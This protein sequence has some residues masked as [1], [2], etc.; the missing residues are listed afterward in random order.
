[1]FAQSCRFVRHQV[2]GLA[3]GQLRVAVVYAS[4]DCSDE[5]ERVDQP[6]EGNEYSVDHE[7]NGLLLDY[8]ELVLEDVV[9]G[10]A[11]NKQSHHC[12]RQEESNCV[13]DREVELLLGVRG[14]A[15]EFGDEVEELR[16][17]EFVEQHHQKY[18]KVDQKYDFGLQT[19]VV[20]CLAVLLLLPQD[21][22]L[23]LHQV[24]FLLDGEVENARD[25]RHEENGEEPA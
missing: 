20:R 16:D 22:D 2:V 5:L 19:L 7:H 6:Q 18:E 23:V 10:D 1:M 21:L 25:G 24:G 17:G 8:A 15:L 13:L 12:G 3:L 4:S 9:E 14:M 11:L